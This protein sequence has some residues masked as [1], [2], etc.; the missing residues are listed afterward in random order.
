M[1][2]KNENT[3]NKKIALVTLR[4]FHFL[5]VMSQVVA[6]VLETNESCHA[7]NQIPKRKRER[8]RRKKETEEIKD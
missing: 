5:G 8:M 6:S 1:K 4:F 2:D 7:Q 3:S